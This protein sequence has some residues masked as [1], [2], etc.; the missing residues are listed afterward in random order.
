MKHFR[1]YLFLFIGLITIS[2][3]SAQV[4]KQKE[5]E[6]KRQAIL[7]EIKQINSLLFKTK[8]EEKSVLSQVEDLN[9]R[10]AAS[11]NLIRVTNQQANLLTRNIN[12]NIDK[13]S[14]LR[15]EL[16]VM[17]ADYA[18]MVRK[19]YKSKNQQS[20]IMFLLSSQNF[21]QAYKRVQY[22]KQYAKFRKKQGESI[23]AKT[24]ELQKLNAD[25]IEQKKTKQKLIA[26]NE[27]AKSQLTSERK[28]QQALVATLKKDESKF[29]AQIRTKQ[30]QADEIDRQ[31]DALIKA[32]IEEANR[33]A[34]EKAL[35]AEKAKGNTTITTTTKNTITKP[36]KSEEFALTAEDRALAASFTNNKGK[37]P[38]PVEKGMVVKSFGTHQHPQFPNVTTNS[39]GVEIATEDNAEVRSIFEGQ[40]MSIQII[41]GAN[42]VVFI[43][44]GDYISVYSNLATVS[45]KK[46]DKVSTKQTIGTVAKSATEG[47]TV[48]KFYI[49]QNK[50]KINPADWIYRM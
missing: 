25:L 35:A 41:K 15:E 29:T 45:V 42:K 20:R 49:Y 48:L 2:T 13:I 28:D 50:T 33:I 6:E 27:V 30:K 19:S 18:E 32:A 4:D 1:T 40:V 8:K 31:I 38:W 9:Q 44:H 26:E 11:E 14:T 36:A 7:E 39:S 16:K 17:K 12:D 43:Q 21:L 22:M 37:L 10:I 3:V 23:K 46:G 34:R 47:R 24:E 5:L